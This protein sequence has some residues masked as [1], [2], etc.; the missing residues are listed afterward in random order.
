FIEFTS[1]AD[2]TSIPTAIHASD[3]I[4]KELQSKGVLINRFTLVDWTGKRLKL[5]VNNKE[6]YATLV[7]TD[8]WP[9]K[10]NDIDI[11]VV[12]PKYVPDS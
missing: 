8:N 11:V 6:D 4:L 2:R 5:G 9:T 12:K 1:D 7:G 10:I 3:L